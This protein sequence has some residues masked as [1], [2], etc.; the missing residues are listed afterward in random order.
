M[1]AKQAKEK[2]KNKCKGT[3]DNAG[4]RE[5]LQKNIISL[6]YSWEGQYTWVYS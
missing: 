5:K 3:K 6:I 2:Q 4:N 1:R